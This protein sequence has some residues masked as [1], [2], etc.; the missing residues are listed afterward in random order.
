MAIDWISASGVLCE[1]VLREPDAIF[2]AI[3]MVD[4]FNLA[5][6]ASPDTV[7]HFFGLI[8]LKALPSQETFRIGVSLVGSSGESTRLPD[9]PENPY[10]LPVYEGDLSIPA[11]FSLAIE[12]RIGAAKM[13]TTYVEVDVDGVRMIRIPFTLRRLPAPLSA[14]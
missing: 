4:I 10:R 11:G 13:G 2:S 3:R 6:D 1:K 8:T 12:F 5:H 9:P 7:V 14:Q